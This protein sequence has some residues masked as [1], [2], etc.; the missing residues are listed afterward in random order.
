MA[1]NPFFKISETNQ[2]TGSNLGF[3]KNL[4]Q[5]LSGAKIS[6]K[7]DFIYYISSA[8]E[9]SNYLR[10]KMENGQLT[11]FLDAHFEG[12]RILGL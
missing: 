9:F 3:F 4:W 2:P 8:F 7:S 1:K 5:Q 12:K 10:P 11:N 6:S